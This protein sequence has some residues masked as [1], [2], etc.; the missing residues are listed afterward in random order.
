MI[1][2]FFKVKSSWEQSLLNNIKLHSI[3]KLI[4]CE[5][6]VNLVITHIF[7]ELRG[8]ATSAWFHQDFLNAKVEFF[9]LDL[10]KCN[11]N[12]ILQASLII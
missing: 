10:I 7:T 1:L 12:F 3:S 6:T 11:I 9:I 5:I 2:K 4:L 8:C